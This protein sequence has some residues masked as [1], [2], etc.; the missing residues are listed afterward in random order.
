[1]RRTTASLLA[2]V[3]AVAGCKDVPTLAGGDATPQSGRIYFNRAVP[4]SSNALLHMTTDAEFN[5]TRVTAGAGTRHDRPAAALNGRYLAW[6]DVEPPPATGAPSNHRLYTEDRWTGE[7]R[8]LL[9][10]GVRGLYPSWT[11]DGDRLAYLRNDLYDAAGD[12]LVISNRDGTGL[13]VILPAGEVEGTMP[14]LSPDGRR[15]VLVSQPTSDRLDVIEVATG[16]RAALTAEVEQYSVYL[17]DPIW[18]PDG[19]QVAFIARPTGLADT[20]MVQVVDRQGVVRH[21]LKTTVYATRPAWSP[22]GRRI[23]VCREFRPNSGVWRR[24][25]VVWTLASGAVQSI[26]PA[27]DSDCDPTWSR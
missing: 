18:S 25:I 10:D 1:M 7:V 26:T 6:G 16:S 2:S 20:S 24:E 4:L 15:I 3:L 23:A 21:E 13:R 22:D 19:E 8:Q 17:R 12:E 5:A 14:S 27:H 9:P 11:R